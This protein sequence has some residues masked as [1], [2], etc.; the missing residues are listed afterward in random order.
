MPDRPRRP[1]GDWFTQPDIALDSNLNSPDVE[2]Y[3]DFLD[4]FIPWAAY[5]KTG[6]EYDSFMWDNAP[7]ELPFGNAP[8]VDHT[9]E[10]VYS[11][12]PDEL[13]LPRS[14]SAIM[15]FPHRQSPRDRYPVMEEDDWLTRL[16]EDGSSQQ[17]FPDDLRDV[18]HDVQTV[19]Y[20]PW[21]DEQVYIPPEIVE[22]V[23]VQYD[24]SI[25]EAE[26]MLSDVILPIVEQVLTPEEEEELRKKNAPPS[27]DSAAQ[28]LGGY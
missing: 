19:D 9:R 18:Q 12:L 26:L 5:I 25:P 16:Y 3:R 13:M 11:L 15:P 7:S 10:S 8:G 17:F 21:Q 28:M 1:P 22:D 6:N 27:A 20:D 4:W 24:M 23:A 2:R 14:S